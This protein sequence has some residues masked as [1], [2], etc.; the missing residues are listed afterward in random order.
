MQTPIYFIRHGQ[1]DWNAALRFQGQQDIPLNETGQQQAKRNGVALAQHLPDPSAFVL[2]CSPMT[3]TRQTLDLA[4]QAA[5]WQD[6]AWAKAVRFD[7]RLKELTFGDWEG[8]TLEEIR[9]REPEL[10]AQREADKWQAC[11]P[12]GESY[13]MLHKRI[14]DWY[15]ELSGPTVVVA[16]GG[17]MRVIR[18]IL[19][20]IPGPEAAQLETPQD[21]IY[22]WTGERSEWL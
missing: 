13:A 3:R 22:F 11:P 15:A 10:Y 6:S 12:N 18:H 2:H 14:H 20:G 17:V 7:D 1:T 16:H 19:E 21:K 9:D 4:M 8:W 5:G